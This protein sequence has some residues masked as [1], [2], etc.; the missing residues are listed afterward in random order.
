MFS[1]RP[2]SRPLCYETALYYELRFRSATV[3]RV[4]P[5]TL[6]WFLGKEATT[7]VTLKWLIYVLWFL[8]VQEHCHASKLSDPCVISVFVLPHELTVDCLLSV[9]CSGSHCAPAQRS[10]PLRGTAVSTAHEFNGLYRSEAQRSLP[11][12]LSL[13]WLPP[14]PVTCSHRPCL[15]PSPVITATGR[16]PAPPGPPHT[17]RE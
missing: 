9:R 16:A 1:R 15:Q 13:Q 11:P 6:L 5:S 8:S 2:A 10:L 17:N 12:P 14:L 7:M 3:R 4:A